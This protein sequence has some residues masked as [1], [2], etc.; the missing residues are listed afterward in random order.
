MGLL[1]NLTLSASILLMAAPASQA[2]DE[3][4]V[5][6]GGDMRS[7]L[8]GVNRDSTTDTVLHH[9][10]EPLVAARDDLS[11][12]PALAKSWDVSEDGLTYT[13]TLRDGAV[14]HNG[15]P[16]LAEHVKW[17]WERLLDEETGF[18]CRRWFDGTGPTGINI[19][20]IDV[21]DDRTVRFTLEEPAALF[22]ARMAHVVCLSGI[23]HPD[24]YDESG[25]WVGPVATGPYTI[26]DWRRDQYVELEKFDGYVP[27]DMP[28]DGYSGAR[29]A[30]ADT[31]R[32]VVI[33]D[34]AAAKSALLAGDVDVLPEL[35]VDAVGE[36]KDAG[37]TVEIGSTPGWRLLQL[38]N[39]DE[40]LSNVLIRQ[41]I[42]HAINR[43][44]I[45][46]AA[47]AGLGTS[48]PSALA[49]Q[50]AFHGPE[51]ERALDHDPERARALLAEAGY[52]GEE[53]TITTS[54]RNNALY[55]AA[56]V[57]QAQL[58]AVGINAQLEVLEW[59]AHFEKYSSGD[60]QILS[61]GYSARPDATMAL[62][63]FVGDKDQRSN[64]VVDDPAIV[65]AVKRSGNITDPEAR[66]ELLADI[67]NMVLE[68]SSAIHLFNTIAVDA[69]SAN[70]EGYDLWT[71]G[72]PRLWGVS[73]T[74]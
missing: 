3:L 62:D 52:A 47:S 68:D 31:I 63:V 1:K 34:P 56:I 60:Y 49:P 17:S 10:V 42:A 30:L 37:F 39:R 66:R 22:L 13:F 73:V 19:T 36:V 71:L 23:I 33:S 29:D 70:V 16:V 4:R 28:R 43:E 45:T 48:N 8:F 24:S 72:K 7:T 20:G 9:V 51:F 74:E 40:V 67:H 27:L 44:E 64:A 38:Q 65:A 18:L 59:A 69:S 5:A 50:D 54:T 41:A 32:F 55:N 46:L 25:E 15:E 2:A 21:V 12:G 26:A 58:Q 57:T 35:D 6:I 53:I 14:F 11:I 61:F